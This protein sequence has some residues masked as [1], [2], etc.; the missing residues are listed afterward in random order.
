MIRKIADKFALSKQGAVNY[1]KASVIEF[2]SNLISVL[3][4]SYFLFFLYDLTEAIRTHQEMTPWY[5]YVAAGLVIFIIIFIIQY[6]DYTNLFVSTYK[7]SATIRIRLAEKLRE[8]P[9]S[10]YSK[11]NP[12]EIANVL[13]ND[14]ADLERFFSHAMPKITGMIPFLLFLTIGLAAFNFKMTMVLISVIPIAILIYIISKFSEERGH[15]RYFKLLTKQSDQFQE[16][17]ERIREIRI[18]NRIEETKKQ[19]YQ[20]LNEQE[21]LHRKTEI[22]T[23]VSQSMISAV[24]QCGTGLVILVGGYAYIT[25]ELPLIALLIFLLASNK[26]YNLITSIFENLSV[27][28]YT[29]VR[30]ERMRAIYNNKQQTGTQKPVFKNYDFSVENLTFSYDDKTSVLEAINFHAKEGTVT[31]LVGPSGSGKTTVLKI[32]SRL[33]DYQTGSIQ[34]GGH[35]LADIDVNYLF[36][37]ISIV[38]QDVTL[39]NTS[40][41]ENIRIGKEDASD[42]EVLKAAKEA[43]CDEFANN[44]S[45]GYQTIIGEN[46]SLL[47]GGE[48]QRISI[49][50]AFLKNAPILFLDETSSALDSENEV[51]VQQA[52]SKLVEGKTVLVVAH[53]LK[54]IENADEIIVLEAGKIKEQGT[55]SSLLAEKGLFDKLYSYE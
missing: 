12:S 13:L 22:P 48:R 26:I 28:R 45:E 47:S 33:Y 1:L 19:A 49:A 43:Q 27:F 8:L 29:K 37:H 30:I 15:K 16:I 9:M 4:M 24:L 5:I 36:K 6:F 40:I 42:E 23:A 11:K 44:F 21:H 17:I 38:F 2:L 52:L 51:A 32:L 34:L 50:R 18:F 25:G 35:E 41:L 54:T 39:F 55:K 31:A 53:R 46:G 20:L 7:E 14:V 3:P 10:Y